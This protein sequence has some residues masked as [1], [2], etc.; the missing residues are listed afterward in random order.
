MSVAFVTI[1]QFPSEIEAKLL[2]DRLQEAGF[3]PILA[4]NQIYNVRGT[5][6][7][8]YVWVQVPEDEASNAQEIAARKQ[9][10]LTDAESA[11]LDDEA[12]ALAR[13]PACHA[14]SVDYA[15][16]NGWIVGT[17][18]ACGHRWTLE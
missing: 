5:A 7:L 8:A 1:A 10:S 18:A 15:E 2:A 4:N 12:A 14:E 13:C 16:T 11:E 3:H 9:P 6:G 17:C